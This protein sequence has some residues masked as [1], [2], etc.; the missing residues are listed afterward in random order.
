MHSSHFKMFFNICIAR[1]LMVFFFFLNYFQRCFKLSALK[2]YMFYN[3][4][5]DKYYKNN[6]RKR[7]K[8]GILDYQL[9]QTH[10]G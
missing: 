5:S 10:L 3:E 4:K 7:T 8:K 1:S 6:K 2:K 9:E